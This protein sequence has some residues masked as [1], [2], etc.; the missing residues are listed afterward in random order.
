MFQKKSVI[1]SGSIGVCKV[2]DIIKLTDN[3]KEIHSYYSLRSVI[4]NKVSYIPVEGHTVE[5][6]ELI[7]TEEAK[8]M[9]LKV[10]GNIGQLVIDEIEYVLKNGGAENDKR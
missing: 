1:F 2:E 6:R 3:K 9:K 10:D 8:A 4:N 7:S 5:L